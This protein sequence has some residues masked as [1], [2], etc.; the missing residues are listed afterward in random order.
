MSNLQPYAKNQY[1]KTIAGW[2]L[3][4]SDRIWKSSNIYIVY[5][6]TVIQ[7]S[8]YYAFNQEPTDRLL[9]FN[10]PFRNFKRSLLSQAFSSRRLKH[11]R[12]M[13]V[14]LWLSTTKCEFR[15]TPKRLVTFTSSGAFRPLPLLIS[16]PCKEW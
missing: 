9:A 7:F 16:F 5:C 8:Q 1:H 15:W 11:H 4:Y 3:N 10:Q 2:I 6:I 13:K 14:T 12:R